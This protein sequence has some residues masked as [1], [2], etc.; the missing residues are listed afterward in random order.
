M[1]PSYPVK[2]PLRRQQSGHG[3]GKVVL[4]SAVVLVLL[5]KIFL[6]PYT[7][8]YPP[9][10]LPE[11]CDLS[12]GEWVRD[13]DAPYYTNKTCFT[14]QEH[15]NCMKYGRP[16]LDFLKW[17]WQPE[18]CD[19]PRFDAAWFL[20]LVRGKSLAFVGDSLARN[21]MQS[22]MCLLSGVERPQD[23]SDSKDDN[24]KRMFYPTYRVT[25]S[26]FWSPF[27]VKAQLADTDGPN[28]TGLWNLYLD[29]VDEKWAS[30]LHKFDYVIISDGNWFTRPSLFYE[31]KKLVGCH[32]CLIEN[33][34][35]LTLHYSHR[36][37]F[38]T[39]L[40]AINGLAGFKGKV[41]VRSI[42]P[43]HFEN[44]EWNKGGNCKRKRPYRSNETTL[45][46]LDREFYEQQLE[47]FRQAEREQGVRMRLLD[48]TQ[49]MLLRPDGHPS[50]YG[51]SIHESVAM[52][53]DCVHWCL[54]GP[55]DM[56]NQLLFLMLGEPDGHPSRYGHWAH[57]NVTLYNDCVHWCLPGPID[58]WNTLLFLM[59]GE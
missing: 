15:Q 2:P 31:Q 23:M 22:L 12:K 26:I 48:T 18:G 13:P 9:I 17:R 16:D 29:E 20:H 14:I 53:N 28:H 11:N 50:R 1:K 56:W 7:R 39:A 33:V 4:L 21:Q 54:P 46:S 42:S 47:E 8:R 52:Y 55:I 36:M 3:V 59:L 38:R 30:Q 41:F 24:F 10:G 34:T 49:A 5:V 35:D 43:S 27:L 58:M 19:L 32:Y 40:R 51:H 45:E 37:A 25:I 6:L 44:G 57:E